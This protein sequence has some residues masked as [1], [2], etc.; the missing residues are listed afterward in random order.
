MREGVR[1]RESERE[2]QARARART[3]TLANTQTQTKTP[4][5]KLMGRRSFAG[6][7]V[8]PHNRTTHRPT[9]V[10]NRQD[11]YSTNL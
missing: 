9:N 7:G 11:P 4:V 8:S 5:T 10:P 3:H 6:V 1:A 2:M